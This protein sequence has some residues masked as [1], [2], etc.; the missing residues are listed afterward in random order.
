M[1]VRRLLVAAAIVVATPL[2]ESY[3]GPCSQAI[4]RTQAKFDAKLDAAAT[5]GPT[6]TESHAA[7]A[8]HQPTPDSIAAAEEK[9]GIL[10]YEQ[11]VAITDALGRARDADRAGDLNACEQAL[12]QAQ[13]VL[14]EEAP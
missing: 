12:N 2:S 9:L 13:H 3:A 5:V 6:A 8:H 10:S 4:D 1:T 14:G 7:T 11:V